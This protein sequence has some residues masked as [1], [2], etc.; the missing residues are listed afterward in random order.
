MTDTTEDKKITEEGTSTPNS[1]PLAPVIQIPYIMAMP[2]HGTLGTPFFEG[3]NI[4]DFLNQ[5]E[6]MCTD[7]R[8]EKKERIQKLPL[9]CKMFIGKYIESVIRPSGIT[10]TAIRKALR[11]QYKDQDLNQQ[12]YSR[13]FLKSYKDKAP[14]DSSDILHHYCDQFAN[15]FE[16]LVAKNSI[17]SFIQSRWFLQGLPPLIQVELFYSSDLDPNNDLELDFQELLQRTIKMIKLKKKLGDMEYFLKRN[18]PAFQEDLNSNHIHLNEDKKVYLGIYLPRIRPVFMRREKPGQELM[19]NAKKL[20]Y[21]SLPPANVQTLRIGGANP[22]P[23]KFLAAR[24]NQ[25]K[26][27]QGPSKEP[28]ERILH[29]QIEKKNNYAAPK[30]MR[31]GKWESVKDSSLPDPTATVPPTTQKEAMPDAKGTTAKKIVERKKYPRVVNVLKESVGA[32]TITKRIQDLGVNL[33]V[34]ELLASAPAVEKQFTKAISEDKAIQFCV[35]TLESSEGLEDME[36]RSWYSMGSPKAKVTLEDGSKIT[37]LL[38][39]SAEI[40]VII[41][42]IMEDTGLAMQRGPKLELVSHPG[43]SRPFLGLC[44]DVE[45]AIGGLKTRHPIFVVETGDHDLVLG[46][47]FLNFVKFN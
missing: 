38:D 12:I 22:D 25:S 29:R 19:A 23:P 10:W 20:Q 28:V 26:A 34:G 39:T 15:I 4:T 3:F 45:V 42:K 11:S 13:C 1:I 16:N 18:C 32:T 6:L 47:P 9:Y 21:R 31:F 40:H 8:V 17:D 35:N 43:Y 2:Y 37:T 27:K 5:Y 44:E 14:S 46:Q 41:R 7:F 36:P 33:T 24:T 30:N